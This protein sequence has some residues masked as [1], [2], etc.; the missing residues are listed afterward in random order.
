MLRFV[1]FD[2][3][4][5]LVAAE[6]S[7]AEVHA[8]FGDRNDEGLRR[9]NAGEIDDAEFLRTDVAVWHRHRPHLTRAE[10]G[11]ILDEVPL[12]PGAGALFDALR[13]E[14]VTTAIVSGGID[15][16]AD[17]I[18][19]ELRVDR[20]L[21]NGFAID[22]NDRITGEGIIRVPIH[23]KEGVLAKLQQELGFS[24]EETGSVGNS[25]IDV[26]LFRR[27]RVG[28][29]FRPEDEIVRRGA[30]HV[31]E[32]GGLDALIPLLTARTPPRRGS[33]S[34]APPAPRS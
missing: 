1:A 31:V 19:R 29:A 25:E 27:S 6:S 33:G 21:A 9:F 2:M 13:A 3:D 24:P 32:S 7:W 26:G 18:G 20:V 8:Y 15:L 23:G 14:G 28:I 16:L 11:V 5:T 17:R 30:T 10:L 34:G 4:G 22:G 12:M